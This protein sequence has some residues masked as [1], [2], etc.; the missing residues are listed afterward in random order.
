M[1]QLKGVSDNADHE[2][3]AGVT[4]GRGQKDGSGKTSDQAALTDQQ[5]AA[6]IKELRF[7]GVE[8]PGTAIDEQDGTASI[9]ARLNRTQFS[10]DG[11]DIKIHMSEGSGKKLEI[12]GR[13]ENGA[14][15]RP[16][17][18]T[19]TVLRFLDKDISIKEIEYRVRSEKSATYGT[20]ENDVIA[21]RGGMA[22]V[23][24]GASG[25]DTFVSGLGSGEDSIKID[26]TSAQM[27]DL[28]KF[29]LPFAQVFERAN[30]VSFRWK[31]D[32]YF[33]FIELRPT[34]AGALPYLSK[35]FLS[36]TARY[37]PQWAKKEH[38][39]ALKF[40]DR[41]DLSPAPQRLAVVELDLSWEQLAAVTRACRM[42]AD[43]SGARISKTDWDAVEQASHEDRQLM[44]DIMANRDFDYVVLAD[45]RLASQN[46]LSK[47]T[48]SCDFGK[49]MKSLR[50]IRSGRKS[51]Y[52]NQGTLNRG[53]IFGSD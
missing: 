14:F 41:Q 36:V 53:G 13:F 22:D 27:P 51:S 12:R 24:Y 2:A 28:I 31:G 47:I 52:S 29:D 49:F 26:Q 50:E 32:Q 5:L 4:S 35:S 6:R 46:T 23:L 18:V 37:E 19:L 33:E 42:E 25:C 15:V 7:S 39:F 30:E 38:L 8:K 17:G 1:Q 44:N 45:R 9:F 10:F 16:N 48:S 34:S 3:L 20:S 11:Q 43:G 21:G 40:Q